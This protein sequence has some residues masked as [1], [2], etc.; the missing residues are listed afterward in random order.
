MV[1]PGNKGDPMSESDPLAMIYTLESRENSEIYGQG[2][3]ACKLA[4]INA[5]IRGSVSYH[6][7]TTGNH[8]GYGLRHGSLRLRQR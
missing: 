1:Y 3:A 4:W 2:E 7:P 6:R 8:S 5:T